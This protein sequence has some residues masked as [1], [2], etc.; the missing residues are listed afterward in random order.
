VVLNFGVPKIKW[1]PVGCLKKML[2]KSE[3]LS[4]LLIERSNCSY[5]KFALDLAMYRP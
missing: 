5:E 3:V 4:L 1:W 2:Q